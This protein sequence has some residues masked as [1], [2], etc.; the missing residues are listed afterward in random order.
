MP[1]HGW[2][3][4]EGDVMK[5]ATRVLCLVLSTITV[6]CHLPVLDMHLSVYDEGII[7]AGA[8]RVLQGHIPYRDFW[9]MYPPGQFYTLAVLF[10]LFGSSVLVERVYDLAVRSLLA[11]CGFLITRKLGLSKLAAVIGWAMALIW[12][13]STW[14]AAYPVYAALVLICESITA[15]LH[16]LET[17]Q[18]RWLF[19][20]GLL[21]A[22]A[23]TFRHDLGAMA[24]I[25]V[26]IALLVKEVTG[27]DRDWRPIGAYLGGGLLAALPVAVYLLAAVGIGPV[28]DQL[29][30]TPADVMPKYRWLPYPALSFE[31]LAFYL[32][33]L[34]LCA[35]LIL[36]LIRVLKDSRRDTFTY[37]L[38][39]L[40]LTGLLFVNQVR[41]RSDDIHLFPAAM[42]SIF[43]LP[44]LVSFF[45]SSSHKAGKAVA[46]VLVLITSALFVARA[47]EKLESLARTRFLALNRS[48][49]PRAGFAWMGQDLEDVVAMIKDNTAENEAIYVG[50]KNHDQ[51]LTNDVIIPFLADRPYATRYHELHPGV[52]T[53]SSVQQEIVRELGDAPVRLIVLRPGYWPEPNQTGVDRGIDLLDRYI[54]E[55][56]D[57]FT[58]V[59][60]YELWLSKPQ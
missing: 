27:P 47:S 39:V 11:L 48:T 13:A 57:L 15:F 30:A 17:K 1:W 19:C 3:A 25:A 46:L 32:F 28:W 22:L 12:T 40:S 50:V 26:L 41:V 38:F 4:A 51:F 34:V 42:A 9:S 58:K 37:G 6:V 24:A 36:S 44:G 53:T 10:K 20:S 33:P 59:G 56:Y 43:V 23:A 52:T 55:N 7:L 54:A 35:S 29:V 21:L 16:H 14:F 18:A 60:T 31:T 45:L 2:R 5:H 49:I 8:D